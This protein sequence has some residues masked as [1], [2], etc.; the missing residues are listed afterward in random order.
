MTKLGQGIF[1]KG[2]FRASEDVMVEGRV[3]GTM[4]CEHG[5]VILAA[6]CDVRGDIL[7][8]DITVFGRM[9]GKLVGSEFVDLRADCSVTGQV[10]SKR[11]ILD[12]GAQFKGRA[13]PQ[14]VEAALRVAK[15]QQRK[16]D[17]AT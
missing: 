14:H 3:E 9:T 8:R 2:E 17:E 12:D 11:F 4:F 13:E 16:Q 5:S 7:A 6:S 1:V 15:F 10:L